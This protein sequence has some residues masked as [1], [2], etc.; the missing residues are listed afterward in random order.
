MNRV[1]A[2]AAA[3]CIVVFAGTA[4]ANTVKFDPVIGANG[5]AYTGHTEDG[6]DVAP[7]TGDWKVATVFGNP[8]PSIFSSEEEASVRVTRSGGGLFNFLSVDFGNAGFTG[9]VLYWNVTGKRNGNPTLSAAG[10]FGPG[11]DSY[12]N[13]VSGLEFDE[14]IFAFD[15]TDTAS[16]NIDNI[17]VNPIAMAPVPLPASFGFL[18]AGLGGLA[19]ARRKSA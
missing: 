17:V 1:L 5:A 12:V 3:A 7:A 4:S 6:F 2:F 10:S 14:L 19:F 11:F 13:P 18:L 8:T 16:F 9:D 15:G